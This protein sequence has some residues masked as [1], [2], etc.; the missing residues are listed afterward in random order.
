MDGE[1][2]HYKIK[3]TTPFGWLN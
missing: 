3:E 2:R 1:R